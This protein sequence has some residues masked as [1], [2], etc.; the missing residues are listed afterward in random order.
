MR[1]QDLK[2]GIRLN[3]IIGGIIILALTVFGFYVNNI[4]QRQI[5]ETTDE[6]MN[7]QVND[8]VEMVGVEL[9][10]NRELVNVSLHLGSNY[11]ARQGEITESN[12]EVVG[13]TARNQETGNINNVEVK[14]WYQNGKAIHNNFDVVDAIRNMGVATTTIFQKI[15]QG[16]LR[17]STNVM[18][19]DGTRAVGTFIP[20]NSPVAQAID[21]GQTYTGRAWVVNDWYLTGYEPIYING[22]IKGMIYVGIPE[23]DLAQISNLFNNKRFFETGYPYI[24]AA[25]GTLIVHPTSIGSNINNERF[26]QTMLDHKTGQTIRD[27]YVWEGDNKVQ[28]FKY[29]E[30]IDAFI[31][32]GFYTREMNRILYQMRIAI[33]IFT[34]IAVLLVILIIRYIVHSIVV[35]LRKGVDLAETIA[36]GNLAINV[37]SKLVS[38]KDEVGQLSRAMQQ[39]LEKLREVIGG[40]IAGSDNIAAASQQM[41]STAQEM[42][43]GSTEQASSAEE[44]SS[45]MEEMSANIQQ[46]TDNAR[47]TEKISQK[48]SEGIQQV[49]KAADESVQSIRA[50]ASKISIIGEISRQTNIL[51]LNAAVEAARAGEHG[52]GFAVVAAEVRKLAENSK[53]AADEINALAKTSVD[54]TEKAGQLMQSLIP[55]VDRTTKLVQEVS[56]ASIEQN[57]G[58]EQV[59]SAIQQLNQVTQQNAAASEEMATSSEELASQADQ[60]LEIVSYFKLDVDKARAKK[61]AQAPQ[62]HFA[63]QN[64][65]PSSQPQLAKTRENGKKDTNGGVSIYLGSSVKDD[66]Y[67]KF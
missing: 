43:Q 51:A 26:F 58:A 6:R 20:S 62:R 55:E 23:K 54:A 44:V 2:I 3:V 38:Q 25:D 39:M 30:P 53:I 48:V 17:I 36:Q 15:P 67:E 56:A 31:S 37:D 47:E 63:K 22:E 60:L 33:F 12:T 11:F 57:S 40:V 8:L 52:R 50:I 64:E 5:I 16:Y 61:K 32:A 35:A 29:F 41:S 1:I 46:N 65:K 24:V 34:G 21:R 28:Y 59:N 14:K 4:L 27:E 42:S 19:N 9:Q 10:K 45:S 66:E 49:G 7:E 18:N 13:F